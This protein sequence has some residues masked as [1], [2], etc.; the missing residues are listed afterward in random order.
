[1]GRIKRSGKAGKR[2]S[3]TVLV[4]SSTRHC[5]FRRVLFYQDFQG[6]PRLYWDYR[7]SEPSP[8]SFISANSQVRA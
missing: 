8:A 6:Q 5:Y 3:G 1:M 7:E 4:D 2:V